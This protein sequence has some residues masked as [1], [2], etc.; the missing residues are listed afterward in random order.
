MT[1]LSE[2]DVQDAEAR[3]QAQ[4]AAQPT[5]VTARYDVPTARIVV[6]LSNGLELAFPPEF[7]EVLADAQ[8]DELEDIEL[9]PTG[10]GLHF[11]RLD[12]DLYLPALV[13]AL[14]GVTLE[15]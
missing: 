7:V 11:P 8:A 9:S 4:L 14:T 13:Q 6:A 3:L 1:P 2:Q 15:S 5:A 10:L 12:A